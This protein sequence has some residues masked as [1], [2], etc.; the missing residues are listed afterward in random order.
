MYLAPFLM[1]LGKTLDAARSFASK[2][3]PKT[4]KEPRREERPRRYATCASFSARSAAA[5][6]SITVGSA[7][8][9]STPL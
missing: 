2:I 6:A 3:L 1:V 5:S 4:V 8:P 7:S 9:S